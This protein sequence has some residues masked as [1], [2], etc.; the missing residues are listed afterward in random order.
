MSSLGRVEM[1]QPGHV[2]LCRRARILAHAHRLPVDH[3][4]QHALAAPKMQHHPPPLPGAR[5]IEK[6]AVDPGRVLIRHVRRDVGEGHLHV[7]IM[8][9]AK[10]LHGPVARHLDAVPG[11]RLKR[12]QGDCFRARLDLKIPLPVQ[13]HEPGRSLPLQ[14]QRRIRR[15]IR[16]ERCPRGQFV[17]RRKLGHLPG[18][19]TSQEQ[20]RKDI[21]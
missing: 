19:I 16:Q 11:W 8:R 14:S 5:Q 6:L 3:D 20:E 18:F 13:A 15:R 7:G 17:D 12:V 2:K 4:H 10:T 1:N 21:R 9:L